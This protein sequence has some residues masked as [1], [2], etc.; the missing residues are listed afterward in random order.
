MSDKTHSQL[1]SNYLQSSTCRTIPKQLTAQHHIT[2]PSSSTSANIG[3]SIITVQAAATFEIV[4]QSIQNDNLC[5]HVP[6]LRCRRPP[7]PAITTCSDYGGS[8]LE[9]VVW[10]RCYVTYVVKEGGG[11]G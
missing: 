8:V 7:G 9:L 10:W 6:D 4:A 1:Q 3:T 2:T 11:E 5:T